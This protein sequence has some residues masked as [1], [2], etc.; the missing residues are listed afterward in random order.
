MAIIL[1]TDNNSLSSRSISHLP[2]HP[3]VYHTFL[4]QQRGFHNFHPTL[5]SFWSLR[6]PLES[7]ASRFTPYAGLHVFCGGFSFMHKSQSS[8]G[9]FLSQ[10]DGR[11]TLRLSTFCLHCGNQNIQLPEGIPVPFPSDRE[12]NGNRLNEIQGLCA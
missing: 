2:I 3:S 9:G 11:M 10:S 8:L 7:P 4:R 12:G 6:C 5:S 1:L